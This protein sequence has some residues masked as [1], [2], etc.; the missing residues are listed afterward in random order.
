M[1]KAIMRWQKDPYRLASEPVAP[2]FANAVLVHCFPHS[3]QLYLSVHGKTQPNSH[4]AQCQN[5]TMRYSRQFLKETH[6]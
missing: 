4:V 1:K 6:S 2:L 5:I 3:D